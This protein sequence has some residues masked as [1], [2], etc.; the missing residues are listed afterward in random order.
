VKPLIR[1][2][3]EA[4]LVE[5]GLDILI[6]SNRKPTTR[7]ARAIMKTAILSALRG[8]AGEPGKARHMR[9]GG[10]ADSFSRLLPQTAVEKALRF[11]KTFGDNSELLLSNLREQFPEQLQVNRNAL[12]G[13]CC[14]LASPPSDPLH[15]LLLGEP[16]TGK[17]RTLDYIEQICEDA[18]RGGLRLT[19]ARMTIDLRDHSLGLL[20]QADGRV[21]LID[22]F[23]KLGRDVAD[24]LYEAMESGR[25][26]SNSPASPTYE[27][28][29]S[30]IAAANPIEQLFEADH[31]A[32]SKQIRLAIPPALLSRFHLVYI[33]RALEGEELRKIV[34]SSLLSLRSDGYFGP[35][36]HFL[37]VVRMTAPT[38]NWSIPEDC[39]LLEEI[40]SWIQETVAASAQQRMS[41]YV[42]PRLALGIRRLALALAR[43]RFSN[44]VSE[45]D[46]QTGFKIAR[47]C[48]ETALLR[49]HDEC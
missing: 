40:C 23:E 1:R 4:G 49:P 47:T 8:M 14:A 9:A 35:F 34:K 25:V 42:T 20:R 3:V 26:T 41:I 15:V 24:Q 18:V 48:Y 12:N 36:R 13:L 39:A 28:R 10:S 44:C 43:M 31:R 29:F 16:A 27:S 5:A 38:P 19:K 33:L 21:L 7:I 30:L 45:N 46:L 11:A 32:I 6:P 17:T 2:V 37:S 22:E